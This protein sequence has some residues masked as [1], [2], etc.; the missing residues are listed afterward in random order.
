MRGRVG[1]RWKE[2]EKRERERM[3]QS[4]APRTASTEKIASSTG[5]WT[6]DIS[7]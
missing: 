5:R 6:N 2:R 7:R 4:E 1:G 3:R